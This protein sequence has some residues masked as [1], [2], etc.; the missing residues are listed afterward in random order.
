MHVHA[1]NYLYVILFMNYLFNK[2]IKNT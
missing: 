1:E 2:F